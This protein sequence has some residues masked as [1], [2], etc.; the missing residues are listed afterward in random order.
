MKRAK[1]QDLEA[2]RMSGHETRE[3]FDRYNIIDEDHLA[4]AGKRLEEYAQSTSGS[5]AARLRLVK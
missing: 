4:D 1:L 2:M 3:V 5:G